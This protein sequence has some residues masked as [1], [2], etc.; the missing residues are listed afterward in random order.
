MKS[1]LRPSHLAQSNFSIITRVRHI[2]NR[3][4]TFKPQHAVSF[5][6]VHLNQRKQFSTPTDEPSYTM[7]QLK[8]LR[9]ISGA[10]LKE[11]KKALENT[12]DA[13]EDR[14]AVALD[15]LRIRGQAVAQQKSGDIAKFGF[16]SMFK[17]TNNASLCEVNCVTDFVEN[18]PIFQNAVMNIGHSIYKHNDNISPNQALSVEEISS[19]PV[20]EYKTGDTVTQTINESLTDIV[21]SIRENL[22]FRRAYKMQC[23]PS[24]VICGY[25]H[26][27]KNDHLGMKGS[28]VSLE[29]DLDLDGIS[30]GDKSLLQELGQNVATHI[31]K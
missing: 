22:V 7:D 29:T 13:T 4:A 11:C 3:I 16:I 6:P 9:S 31:V 27:R 20:I 12:K 5:I 14:I 28:L 21:S 15:W 30:E 24:G 25:L 10:P 1:V 2:H 26:G 8:E 19:L 18:N 23:S 17:D